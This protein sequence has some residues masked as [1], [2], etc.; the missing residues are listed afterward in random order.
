MVVRRTRKYGG[1]RRRR[2]TKRRVRKNRR[3]SRRRKTRGGKRRLGK[4][5]RRRRR[6]RYSL[7]GMFGAHGSTSGLYSSTGDA[8]KDGKNDGNK[9]K[10]DPERKDD[11]EYQ[12]ANTTAKAL[13]DDDK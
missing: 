11:P 4:R 12:K 6:R 5:S 1:R 10:T 9:G 3:V 13:S 7:G 8:A 2:R